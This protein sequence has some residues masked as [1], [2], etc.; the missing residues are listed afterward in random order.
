MKSSI[1]KLYSF[2]QIF[3]KCTLEGL[4]LIA[5][6]K[7]FSKDYIKIFQLDPNLLIY[8]RTRFPTM[9]LSKRKKKLLAIGDRF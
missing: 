3:P 5:V 2:S 4:N 7:I 6:K 9:S 8:F 1:S